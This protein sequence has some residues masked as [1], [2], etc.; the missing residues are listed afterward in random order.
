M[1]SSTFIGRYRLA[2]AKTLYWLPEEQAAPIV[3]L[4][5]QIA[6]ILARLSNPFPQVPHA[7]G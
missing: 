3:A 7:A 4:N 1:R 2:Q 5:A 6:A